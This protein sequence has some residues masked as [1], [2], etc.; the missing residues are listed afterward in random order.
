MEETPKYNNYDLFKY[1]KL[2][3][4]N[5]IINYQEYFIFNNNIIKR[6]VIGKNKNEIFIKCK[7][8][9]ISFTQIEL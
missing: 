4:L 8:Y 1:Q 3:I 7:N 2:Q 9:I 5:D 6:I